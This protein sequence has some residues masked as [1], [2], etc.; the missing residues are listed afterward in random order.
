MTE[1][2]DDCY[3]VE[4]DGAGRS[5]GR[6]YDATELDEFEEVIQ[7][8][9]ALYYKDICVWIVKNLRKGERDLLEMEIYLR[10]HKGVD[11]KP[12]LYIA[13]KDVHFHLG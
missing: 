13:L 9:K 1:D 10:H 5:V 3:P 7:K 8:C 11:S 4:V 6:N 2:T 12:K